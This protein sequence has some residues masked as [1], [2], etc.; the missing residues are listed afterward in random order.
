MKKTALFDAHLRAG[1]KMVDFGGWNMP[2]NYGSQIDEH[3]FVRKGAGV[4][5]VSHMTVI[6]VDGDESQ[7]FLLKLLA[8]D[9]IKLE[10]SKALYTPMLNEQGGII[11]DLIVYRRSQKNY[12]L[13][14]NA[15]TRDKDLAWIEKQSQGFDVK[16]EEKPQLAMLAV[17]GPQAIAKCQQVLPEK[18]AEKLAEVKKFHA[19]EDDSYFIGRTG[20]TGEDGVEILLHESEVEKLWDELLKIDVKPCG[21]GARDTLR[22][23]AGMHLYGQDMDENISPLEC[24]LAWTIRKQNQD[25][26]G[27]EA[28]ENIKAKGI[29]TQLIGVVLN[30]RGILRHDQILVDESANEVGKITSGSFSPSTEKAIGMAIVKKQRGESLKVKIRKKELDVQVV[31]LPF[32]RNGKSLIESL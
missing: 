19:I 22:L 20:Y 32:V 17:Q 12:R 15:S 3:H 18:L 2:I 8:N 10:D 7:E 23:E 13:I 30:G 5:D 1:A 28:L 29:E 9:V 31:K 11:D 4:F 21:L 16:V 26:I 6:D 25:F 14:V 24:G 27:A